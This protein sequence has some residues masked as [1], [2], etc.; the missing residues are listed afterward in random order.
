VGR[1]ERQRVLV[2]YAPRPQFIAFHERP[3][4]FA[5]I[6]AHRRFG[7]TVGCIND[8]QR[9][10]LT[11]TR[12]RPRFAY[13]A[14]YLK[15]AKTVAWDYLLH[16]SAPIPGV[17]VNHSEL[18]VDYPNGGQVR[19]YGADNAD[20]MRGIYL[21]GVVMDEPAD[22]DPRVWPE[23]IRPALSD[24]Q[25]WAAFIGTPKGRNAFHEIAEKA[26]ASA[27]WFHMELKASQTGVLPKHELDAARLDM[28]PDQYAQEY[29]C[30]F[31]AAI[32]GAYYA[33]LLNEG[34]KRIS[35]VPHDP[36]LKVTTAW[37]LGIGDS[38]A[39]W[40]C[41]RLGQEVRI[42]D[43]YEASGEAL[44][45]YAKHLQ[46]L[47][48]IY[49]EHLLPHDA[50]ARELGTG[51]TRVETLASLGIK[52]RVIPA[53]SVEDGINAVRM[54][55]PRC[56]FDSENCKVGLE[57]LKQYRTEFDDKRKVFRDRPLHDWTSHSADAFRILAQGLKV[58]AKPKKTPDRTGSWMG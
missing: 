45:H 37:D 53:Q 30:S 6:V 52:G 2:P 11:C 41:Q 27:D 26:K 39:I 23:I 4:R 15:Q 25:G 44:P 24:R 3:Q 14:P 10:A 13:I 32:Q 8:L 22:M 9:G 20:G 58:P 38:T 47:P 46:S 42:I 29:E 49:D 54:L 5:C 55:I 40:F 51:K 33:K 56:W 1:I 50:D 28:T 16:F 19:L 31:D 35:R 57:A 17:K 36:A 34:Q 48:Y 12:E 7:K 43:H 21:D 18:K